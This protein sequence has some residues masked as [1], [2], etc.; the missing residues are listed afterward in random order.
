[1]AVLNLE[2]TLGLIAPELVGR[3]FKDA[4]AVAFFSDVRHVLPRRVG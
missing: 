2:R 1:M 4:E 3:K